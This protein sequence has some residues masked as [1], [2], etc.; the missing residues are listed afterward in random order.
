MLNNTLNKHNLVVILLLGF[1][2]GLPIA[3]TASTLQ[4]WFT[5]S[6]ASLVTIGMLGLIGQ[7]YL[8]KFLWAP[9]L[10]RYTP[11]FLGLRRGWLL[12]T[13]IGLLVAIVCM[14]M[15]DPVINPYWLGSF[16]FIIA[17]LSA[18]QDIAVNAY[19][20]DILQPQE[21][22]LGAA[23]TVWG[24]RIAMLVSGGAAL[25]L[26]D[27]LGWRTTYLI[28]AGLMGIGIL[29]TLYSKEPRHHPRPAS[30]AIAISEPLRE[31]FSRPSAG[32]FLAF[33]LFYKFGDALSVSLTTPFLIRGLGF[34]LTTVGVVNKGA[35]MLATLLGVLCGG[36]L[37][38]RLRL[39]RSLFYFGVLQALSIFPL[40]LLAL[41]GKNYFMLVTAIT[42]DNFCTGMSSVAFVA[43][44][45]N[46]CDRRYTATQFALFSAFAAVGR[47][48]TGPIAG[49][50]ALHMSWPQ[51]FI[52]ALLGCL[53]GLL[54]L[55]VL[56]SKVK[57][58]A[59]L[60]PVLS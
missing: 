36:L 3:L 15:G 13:Q 16:A 41:L 51:F 22:G 47:V 1:A 55:R 17:M 37:M 25:I 11:P 21:R 23:L 26:A 45:M 4:A 20:T 2:S 38:T 46:L 27:Y 29:T 49:F 30:L 19:S 6:G 18:T 5:V 28:L 44:L 24:Y 43:L 10:D 32:L 58:A 31:F 34:T 35:G 50:M 53:P 9:L 40:L 33:I 48:F 56:R 14:A 7:P 52:W 57:L 8:Y 59:Q 54:I 12:L 60:D 39:Y 42:V